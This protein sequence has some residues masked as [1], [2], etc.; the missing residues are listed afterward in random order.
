M[1]ETACNQ[2]NDTGIIETGNND[3]PCDC[4]AGNEVLFNICGFDTL[5]SGYL[6][7]YYPYEPQESISGYRERLTNWQITINSLDEAT[8]NRLFGRNI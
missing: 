7:K 3:L 4:P 2:C 8:R 5:I 6:L 1:I